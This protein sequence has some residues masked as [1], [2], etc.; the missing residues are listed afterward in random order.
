MSVTAECK[1]TAFKLGDV[2]TCDVLEW[3]AGYEFGRPCLLISPIVREDS[4]SNA[5]RLIEDAMIDICCANG[6]VEH[7]IEQ[8][9]IEWRGWNLSRLRRIHAEV[10][11]GKKYPRAKYTVTRQVFKLVLDEHKEWFF[12]Q[13][14]ATVS[15]TS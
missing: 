6:E 2:L 13:V 10:L 12:E 3:D 8:H 11:A 7:N 9:Q 1:K 14:G 5:E 15:M 4:D